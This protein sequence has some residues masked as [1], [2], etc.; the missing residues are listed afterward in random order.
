LRLGT[1]S[2][3]ER[4]HLCIGGMSTVELAET[5]GTPLY[6]F[7]E[8][9]IRQNC[10]RY[11]NAQDCPGMVAYAAK[12]FITVAMARLVFQEGL[13]LDVVSGGEL[14]TAIRAGFPPENI[15]FNGNNKTPEEI[16]MALRSNVGRIVVD[17]LD[18]LDMLTTLARKMRVRPRI[19]L[20]LNPGVSAHAHEYVLT[21]IDDCKFG[22]SVKGGAA[23]SAVMAA[24][25][26]EEV[27]L[28]GYHVHIGSQLLDLDAPLLAARVLLQF[29]LQASESTGYWPTELD[30]GG[31]LGIKYLLSDRPPEIEQ[32]VRALT[33][34][35][36]EFCTAHGKPLPYLLFEPGRSIVGEAGTTLYTVGATKLM[37][38][39][40]HLAAVDGGMT[41]N[42]RPAL[43][44]AKYHCVLANR[45]NDEPVSTYRIVGK[46]CESGDVLIKE[47]SL[48]ELR[49]GDILAVLSTGAYNYSMA[50]NYNRVARPAA[51]LVSSGRADLIVAREDFS[52]LVRLD[53]LPARLVG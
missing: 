17:S 13:G 8:D 40:R 35:V 6:V 30:L 14:Y 27:Q 1:M 24:L 9:L 37:P 51:V 49:K 26:A 5:Y 19:L 16:S 21:G 47:A 45:V 22:I 2:V 33:G 44:D 29:A 25:A 48:P 36:R 20:R 18:E 31:G 32:Y 3:N 23:L 39:D 53:L 7:D 38:G 4:G 46:C 52:D 12:A 15:I 41:D 34:C 42:P 28:V 50:S 10:R 43:Y 11:V